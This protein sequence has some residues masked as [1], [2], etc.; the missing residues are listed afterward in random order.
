MDFAL[1]AE[2]A[3]IRDMARAFGRERIAPLRP[4]LGGRAAS[5][6]PSS[7][8][9]APSASPPCTC[10]RTRAAPASPAS[11]PSSSSRRWPRPAPPSPPSSRSTT[12]A[13]GCSRSWGTEAARARYLPGLVTLERY[14]AY[15]LTEPGSG[16]DAA[17]LAHPRHPHR[18]RLDASPAPRPSSPAAASP[19]STSSWPAPAATARRAS[20]PSSSRPPPP[21]S[22]SAPRSARWAGGPSRP[23]R[24]SS[25]PA[26]PR[27]TT[28]S[29]PRATAS[30]T[31]WPASTAAGSTSPPPPSAAPRPPSTRRSPTPRER[32]AF[33][34]PL[35][36]FQ[37]L[38]FRLADMET[39][40]QAARVFL[41]QAAWKLDRKAPDA[42]KACAMAKRL[43]TDTAFRV[44]NDA[45][46]LLGGYGY[47][48]D[49][50][51]EKI[52]RDLRVHRDPRRHQRDHAGH[53]RPRPARGARMTATIATRT[54]GR[55]GRITLTRPQALNALSLAMVQAIDAALARLGRRPRR[56]PRPH[57]RRR[58][59]RLLRR[60]RHRRR[61]PLRPPRRLRPRPPLLGRRV[62][63]E[64]PHRPAAPNPTSR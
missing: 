4:R 8:R 9:P 56:R 38:Q 50:G 48:A 13:P 43:V 15:C 3:A 33:G 26:R 55:A 49:Y 45:L 32:R 30:A 1:S 51:I 18:R 19:T 24:S 57:R 28:C 44:A 42:T 34:Q 37:A 10:P 2:Q 36:E 7:P 62:P 47:L 5:P 23:P 12:C 27:P 11:T 58:P 53:H 20:P 39:E 35:D 59:A 40:L 63:D 52:V 61:L 14:C 31:P 64:R 17:A 16:S 54:E 21:A 22:P 46:Q 60:R 41:Y 25:T 6:A 29:A